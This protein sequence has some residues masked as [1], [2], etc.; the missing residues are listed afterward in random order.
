MNYQSSYVSPWKSVDDSI[1]EI[2]IAALVAL[3]RGYD[4]VSQLIVWMIQVRNSC[5]LGV[6]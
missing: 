2:I 3:Q 5:T 6:C 1:R 4:I